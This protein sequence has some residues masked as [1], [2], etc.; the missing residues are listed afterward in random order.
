[1][2]L[3]K[4]PVTVEELVHLAASMT[5]PTEHVF[6]ARPHVALARAVAQRGGTL[7][8]NGVGGELFF[9]DFSY[10]NTL[11]QKRRLFQLGREVLHW[12]LR[13]F[14]FNRMARDVFRSLQEG[15]GPFWGMREIKPWLR[16]VPTEP[17]EDLSLSPMVSEMERFYTQGTLGAETMHPAIYWSSGVM[18]GAPYL[19]RR[20]LEFAFAIPLELRVP[21]STDELGKPLLRSAFPEIPSDICRRASRVN[22]DEYVSSD[23]IGCGGD[24]ELVAMVRNLPPMFDEVIDRF[25]LVEEVVKLR[26]L[27][28]RGKVSEAMGV[29]LWA[30]GLRQQG[31][32]LT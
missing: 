28:E 24:G 15:G 29:A 20:M 30:H 13:G 17:S 32:V 16:H 6:L 5:F 26:Q 27:S 2:A 9:G 18:T 8:L 31:L 22:L 25:A 7:L 12:R 11:L 21:L 4:E 19:D 14:R 1:V 3:S 23:W 10:L